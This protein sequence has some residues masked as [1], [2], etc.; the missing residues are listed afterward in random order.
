MSTSRVIVKLAFVC[1]LSIG[2]PLHVAAAQPTVGITPFL[3]TIPNVGRGISSILTV[4][5]SAGHLQIIGAQRITAVLEEVELTPRDLLTP[6]TED[7]AQLK[8]TMDYL[9]AGEV[10]AF[11]IADKDHTADL[12]D[13]F[14]DLS[15][16]MGEGGIVAHVALEM[17]LL[18]TADGVEL[19]RWTVEGLESREGTRM[20]TLTMGWAGSTDFLTDEFRE[21]MIGHAT[22]KAIGQVLYRL[23]AHFPLEGSI[24]GISGDAMVVD[25]DDTDGLAIGDELT[26]IRRSAIH[27]SQ[28]EAVWVDDQAIGSAEVVEFQPGRCLCLILEG[29]GMIAEGDIAIPLTAHYTLPEYTDIGG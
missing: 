19:G 8:D 26:I 2:L 12:S 14:N 1:L 21:T 20:K 15:R 25:F 9:L 18:R 4:E 27:N 11:T 7:L 5:A 6:S 3:A 23:F 10:I 29:A 22:Y 24:I 13:E 17:R 16:M 28:G